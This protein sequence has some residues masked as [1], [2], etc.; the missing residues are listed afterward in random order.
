MMEQVFRD[1]FRPYL[2]TKGHQGKNCKEN[3]RISIHPRTIEGLVHGERITIWSEGGKPNNPEKNAQSNAEKKTT[4]TTASKTTN[5]LVEGERSRHCAIH[6]AQV[7]ERKRENKERI[8]VS[9][10]NYLK[11]IYNSLTGYSILR[12]LP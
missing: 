6:D 1:K 12:C 7:K 8:L 4:M 9:P 3:V 2:E 5:T 10:N 11:Y